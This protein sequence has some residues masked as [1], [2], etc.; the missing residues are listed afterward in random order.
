VEIA[1]LHK[2]GD[3][4]LILDLDDVNDFKSFLKSL[5]NED[6][7]KDNHL[8]LKGFKGKKEVV[9]EE[10]AEEA[11]VHVDEAKIHV[12]EAKH[13]HHES[14]RVPVE[15][16]VKPE[17]VAYAHEQKEHSPKL[18][19]GGRESLDRDNIDFHPK[20]EASVVEDL[21]KLPKAIP[22]DIRKPHELVEHEG[23]KEP[24]VEF[25]SRVEDLKKSTYPNEPRGNENV[26]KISEDKP[27]HIEKVA[28]ISEDKLL[29]GIRRPSTE[30]SS[31]LPL[32]HNHGDRMILEI[33]QN[34]SLP[35]R[36]KPNDDE[37]F[38]NL[39]NYKIIAP[40]FLLFLVVMMVGNIVR[41]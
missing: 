40:L 1:S 12:E 4:V 5:S 23:Y 31:L 3:T 14:E 22:I 16:E 8:T 27:K 28:K 15:A 25:H 2:E 29:V 34:V 24:E 21:T 13:H 11:K 9:Y 38:V 37:I 10:I 19:F 41:S 6:V 35:A 18:Q 32:T 26:A 39:L 20:L 30:Q 7:I 17:P 36:A 33:V